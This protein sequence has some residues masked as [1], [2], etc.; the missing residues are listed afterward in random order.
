MSINTVITKCPPLR[1]FLNYRPSTLQN[2]KSYQRHG[3]DLNE[4]KYKT[5]LC[6]IY[7]V[8][9]NNYESQQQKN[10]Y[11][12]IVCSNIKGHLRENIEPS[13]LNYF[14]IITFQRSL[15]IYLCPNHSH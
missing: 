6:K 3:V 14:F 2:A 12:N 5:K 4:I 11:I 13:V 9:F 7:S 8:L 1:Q 10:V 15:L